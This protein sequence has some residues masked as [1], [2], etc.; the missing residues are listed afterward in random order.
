MGLV[1][2]Q[3]LR[4]G[5]VKSVDDAGPAVSSYSRSEQQEGRL[6]GSMFDG[7]R[8]PSKVG[9]IPP[10]SGL[11]QL[12]LINKTKKIHHFFF[13]K[14]Q[15]PLQTTRCHTSSTKGDERVW[16]GHLY[17]QIDTPDYTQEIVK[18]YYNNWFYV[19]EKNVVRE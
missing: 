13:T 7:V 8:N 9:K 12:C 6:M 16:A 10:F 17:K 5:N 11:S 4:R 19:N 1:G 2:S 14:V 15:Y 3:N 18:Q